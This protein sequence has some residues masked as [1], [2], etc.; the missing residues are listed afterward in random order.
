MLRKRLFSRQVWRL[1]A[2]LAA[3]LSGVPGAWEGA[4]ESSACAHGAV[5]L[6]RLTLQQV[7]PLYGRSRQE[8]MVRDKTPCGFALLSLVWKWRRGSV[9][10]YWRPSV[11]RVAR[12]CR[13][14]PIR[15]CSQPESDGG[16]S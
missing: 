9:F 4:A 7:D 1:P 10:S 13:L 2:V 6:T 11:R 5:W 14:N 8:I 12:S 15:T 3:E 16:P